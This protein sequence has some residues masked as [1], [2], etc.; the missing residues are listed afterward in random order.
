VNKRSI[1]AL[2]KAG[3]F[4]AI[5]PNRAQA[6]AAADVLSDYAALSHEEATSNQESLFGGADIEVPPPKLPD[7]EDWPTL[8]RLK[9]EM[10][11]IGFYLSGHPLDDYRRSL[12]R[13]RVVTY[14]DLA[15]GAGRHGKP[16]RLAGTI[17]ARHDRKS[18]KDRP[19]AFVEASDSTGQYEALVF[20]D[21]LA[22]SR[23]LLEPGNSVVFSV[24]VDQSE[25]DVRPVVQAVEPIDQVVAGAGAGLKVYIESA[26]AYPGIKACLG[27]AGKGI[28]TLV[29]LAEEGLKEV[30]LDLPGRYKVDPKVRAALKSLK[31][32]AQV[33][34]V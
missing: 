24:T 20:S 19:F 10:E 23:E 13:A 7:L 8:D 21:V 18:A 25:E 2:A 30:H 22:A 14:E 1:E 31:G 3:A 12:A 11:A 6:F 33:E 34:E 4:D 32:V 15:N 17:I 29:I 28:V 9:M 5:H 27:N 26:E 16:M